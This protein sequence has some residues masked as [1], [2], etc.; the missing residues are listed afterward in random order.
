MMIVKNILKTEHYY[1]LYIFFNLTLGIINII[2]IIM[3]L[4]L[5]QSFLFIRV[6]HWSLC[7]LW[8]C[9]IRS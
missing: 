6:S 1:F 9:L 8:K 7:F 4:F 3:D 2:I 5:Q